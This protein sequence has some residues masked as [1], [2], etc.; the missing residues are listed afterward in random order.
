MLET[1]FDVLKDKTIIWVT[2]HLQGIN[3]VDHVVFMNSDE[4]EMEGAPEELYQSNAHFQE[5]Y[6]MDQGL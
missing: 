3:H 4:I 6:K 2:H 1:F 5:L